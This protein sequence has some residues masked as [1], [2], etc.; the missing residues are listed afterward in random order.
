[1]E[2]HAVQHLVVGLARFQCF[3]HGLRPYVPLCLAGEEPLIEWP[4]VVVEPDRTLSV[5]YEVKLDCG[6]SDEEDEQ[7][8]SVNSSARGDSPPSTEAPTAAAPAPSTLAVPASSPSANAG[9]S[10]HAGGAT[11]HRRRSWMSSLLGWRS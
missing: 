3:T 6:S 4:V 7:E 2:Q 10:S 1:M 8:A 5:G 9:S 11:S